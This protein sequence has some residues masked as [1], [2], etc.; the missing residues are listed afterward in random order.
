[1]IGEA[2]HQLAQS[3]RSWGDEPPLQVLWL[4][5][6]LL[7][8]TAALELVESLSVCKKLTSL[9]L[10]EN[11]IGEVGHQLAQSIRSW[12]DEP[13]LQELGL[14]NCSLTA[15]AALE[16]VESLSVCKKL[17]SLDLRENMIG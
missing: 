10:R 6:C 1:M 9:D 11:M 14:Y 8:A 12:G 16:L 15:T 13:P 4:S 7:T 17:T 3:I 5:N 2:G